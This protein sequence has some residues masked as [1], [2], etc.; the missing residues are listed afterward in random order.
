MLT[1]FTERPLRLLE[2]HNTQRDVNCLHAF[3]HKC[4]RETVCYLRSFTSKAS[5]YAFLAESC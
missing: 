4:R 2:E 3:Y 1:I 5:C